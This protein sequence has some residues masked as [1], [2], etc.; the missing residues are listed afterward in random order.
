ML[1]E[2]EK[3]IIEQLKK[4][5]PMS[6]KVKFIRYQPTHGQPELSYVIMHL[7]ITGHATFSLIN[8]MDIR[9]VRLFLRMDISNHMLKMANDLM[10]A[11]NGL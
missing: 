2:F 1:N 11:V 4:D 7:P 6:G 3:A 9:E 5:Y 10:D 8:S